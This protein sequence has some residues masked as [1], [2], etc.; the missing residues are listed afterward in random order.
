MPVVVEE[1]V[2]ADLLIR[3]VILVTVGDMVAVV[4]HLVCAVEAETEGTLV[5]EVP[6]K[7]IPVEAVAV[8]EI[9]IKTVE[10]GA[11]V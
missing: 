8:V 5:L 9:T 1:D 10:P 6:V 3:Q 11:Q 7:L 2:E 4:L